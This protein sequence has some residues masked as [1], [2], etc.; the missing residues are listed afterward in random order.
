M[1]LKV[2]RKQNNAVWTPLFF[3]LVLVAGMYIGFNLNETLKIKRDVKVVI[4]RNDRLE[5]LIDL[6]YDKYLDSLDKNTLY[7]NAISGILKD[8]D[9]HTSYIPEANVESVNDDLRGSFSGIGIE[10][11][12]LKDTIEVVSVVDKSPASTAGIIVGDQLI[13]VG[14]SLVAGTHITSGRIFNLLR[15][16]RRSVVSLTLRN[17]LNGTIK[18]IPV[19]RDEITVNSVTASFLLDTST[20]YIK[21]SQFTSHAYD[22]VSKALSA[23]QSQGA[24]QLV[25]DL[26][27]N[28]GGYLSEATAIANDFFADKKLLVYTAGLHSPRTE[29]KSGGNGSFDTGRIIILINESTASASEI[30]AGAIQDWDRGIIIGRRSF[31]KG[32]VQQ[33][34]ELGDGAV[35]KLT[36]AKYYTP[37]G[38]CIQRSFAEGTDEYIRAYYNRLDSPAQYEQTEPS[39]PD[40]TKYYTANKRVVFAGGG[41]TPDVFIPADTVF[42]KQFFKTLFQGSELREAVLHYFIHNR[43]QLFYKSFNEF[44]AKFKAEDAIIVDFMSALSADDKKRMLKKFDN[45]QNINYIRLQVKAQMAR[46]LFQDNGYYAVELRGDKMV[47]AAR[48]L[49]QGNEYLKITGGTSKSGE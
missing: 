6:L 28:P 41:I 12:I 10:Y 2:Q 44:D 15:G 11:T 37:S 8:L 47:T 24:T 16:K 35:L 29:Y 21:L 4:E 38:R 5:E 23:L 45:I 26:R 20:A 7:D 39:L 36:I 14:D 40:T 27:D 17:S 13:L 34:F 22:E 49:L 48:K 19:T 46:L 42:S 9:P 32:L 33:Q 31:G 1:R 3:S 25:L 18:K 43:S 30:L